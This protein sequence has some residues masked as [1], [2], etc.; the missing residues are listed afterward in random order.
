MYIKKDTDGQKSLMDIPEGL[1]VLAFGMYSDPDYQGYF[2]FLAPIGI[3]ILVGENIQ[4][5]RYA[6]G[7]VR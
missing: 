7:V 5:V 4:G 2:A 1:K 6:E 3:R